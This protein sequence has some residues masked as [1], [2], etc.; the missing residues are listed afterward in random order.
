MHFQLGAAYTAALFA[1]MCLSSAAPLHAEDGP[2]PLSGIS[3]APD[4]VKTET[5]AKKF[6]ILVLTQSMGF[7][8]AA[9]T[10]QVRGHGGLSVVESALTE[11]GEQSGLFETLCSQDATLITAEKLKEFDAL[12]FFTSG[13]LPIEPKVFT[14]IQIWL[15]SGKAFI[16]I[17][18]AT[19]TF[20]EYRP[21][22]EMIGATYLRHPWNRGA[23]ITNLDTTHA[24]V[25]MFPANF[26]WN[27]ELCEQRYF[28]ARKVRVLLALNMAQSS[29][30][31]PKMV[32][33]SWVR[34][35]GK[36]RVF[37]TNFGNSEAVW[38]D[39]SFRAHVLGGVRWAL[40]LD[41]GSAEPNP[42]ISAKEDAKARAAVFETEKAWLAK[43]A[44]SIGADPAAIVAAAAKCALEDKAAFLKL[45]DAI[46][47]ARVDEQRRET[48]LKPKQH[49]TEADM[50]LVLARRKEI[51]DSLTP[52]KKEE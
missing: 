14:Q 33:I 49:P 44:K 1:L 52:K 29:P 9:V 28:D 19:D 32:P 3:L 13:D 7:K 43:V 5:P 22:Y 46:N 10:R 42:E 6:R 20:K 50:K 31:L 16:G 38:G 27:D 45:H 15:R 34:D 26:E 23:S 39:A 25:K 36:G 47:A 40:K 24:A 51:I 41:A 2:A 30:K 17:H 8:H 12:I 37:Y 21:Y 11:I 4:T 48:A 18:S 35:Y